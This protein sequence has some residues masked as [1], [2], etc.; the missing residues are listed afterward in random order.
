MKSLDA[1]KFEPGEW[2]VAEVN[3]LGGKRKIKNDNT[4]NI[5]DKNILI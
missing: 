4:F 2:T 1:E 3:V 5:G